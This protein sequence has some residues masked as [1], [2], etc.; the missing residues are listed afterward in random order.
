MS[1]AG[2]KLFAEYSPLVLFITNREL[3]KQNFL[4]PGPSWANKND[5]P[6][7]LFIYFETVNPKLS[8]SG[9]TQQGWYRDIRYIS[10][11]AAPTLKFEVVRFYL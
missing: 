4:K 8:Q 5:F 2:K 10:R 11:P 7:Y 6:A 3:F 9:S 1:G